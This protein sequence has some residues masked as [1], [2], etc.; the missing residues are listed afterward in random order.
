MAV[1]IRKTHVKSPVEQVFA[2]LADLEKHVEWS[3]ELSFGLEKI[4]K[5][6][7]GPLKEGSVFKSQGKL[8][9]KAGVEETSTVTEVEPHRRLA[10]ETVSD[11]P[12]QQN[13]FCWAYTLEPRGDGTD[14]TYTLVERKFS[15]KPLQM[16]FPLT[17]W[18][19][20]RKV[21]GKEMVAGLHKIRDALEP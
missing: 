20:D 14:L 4:Q 18:L 11:A 21:F 17:L 2:Y 13:T 7:P 6:T 12:G 8:S 3:G 9:Y 19:I 16:L 15:P 10:W 5:V 1:V